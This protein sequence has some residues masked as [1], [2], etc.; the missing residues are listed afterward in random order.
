MSDDTILTIPVN[1]AISA[2]PFGESAAPAPK[3]RKRRTAPGEANGTRREN[4]VYDTDPVLALAC[5]EWLKRFAQVTWAGHGPLCLEPMAGETAPFVKAIRQVWASAR[6]VATDIRGECKDPCLTAGA[7]TFACTDAM[8]LP[9]ETIARADLIATN[10]AFIHADAFI[11]HVWPHL[12][13]G[14]VL[15]L[16]LSITF[17]GSSDRWDPETG[18][19]TKVAMPVLVPQIVPRPS[20]TGESPKFEAALFVFMKEVGG[21]WPNRG[22]VVPTNPVRWVKPRKPRRQ[23]P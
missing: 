9:P 20:F 12:R 3:T 5:V 23:K 8:T 15:A 16:L 4:D 10:P 6:I 18:L 7:D 2:D 1:G 19:F 21:E 17:L 13:E 14:G 22:A 11:R